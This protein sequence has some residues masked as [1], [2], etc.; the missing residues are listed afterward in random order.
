MF[1]QLKFAFI[2]FA[3]TQLLRFVA[4]RHPHFAARLK[5]RNLVAQIKARDEGTGRWIELRDGKIRS[6]AGSH[7]K[8]D[9]TL[10]FKNAAIGASLLTPPINWLA[11]INAQKDFVLGVEGPEDLTNW[12]AQTLMLSRPEGDAA[13]I[14]VRPPQLR[15]PQSRSACPR[16]QHRAD[17]GP[18]FRKRR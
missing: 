8:P 11:Q 12:F 18:A 5:E 13:W 9:I 2:L 16:S 10:L 6:G 1:S 7:P 15:P 14:A 3:L 4:W 17:R